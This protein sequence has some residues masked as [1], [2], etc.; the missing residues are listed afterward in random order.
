MPRLL[1]RRA[2][3]CAGLGLLE[4]LLALGLLGLTAAAAARWFETRLLEERARLAG[5]Q[6]AVL[7]EAAAG[8][9]NG[10]FPALL[11]AARNGPVELA[12]ADLRTAGAL[13]PGFP[14]V[15]ALGRGRRVLI[16][17]AGTD[18]LDVVAAQAVAAGDAAVP[19]A[20]LLEATGRVRLGLVAPDA[21][22]RLAGPALDADVSAFQAAFGGAPA[23]RALASLRRFDH[24]TVFGGQLY[25]TAVPGFPAA[26]RM[27]TDLD[28]GGHGIANAGAIGTDRLTV[29]DGLAVGGAL[30]VAHALIVGEALRVS[31]GAE[32]SGSI[33]AAGARIAGAISGDTLS[34][35]DEVRAAS[36]TAAGAVSAGSIGA[37]GTVAAG[38]ARLGS[39][40]SGT[41]TARSVTATD[42]SAAGAA[43]QAV[44]AAGR[45]DAAEG[46]FSTLTVGRCTGC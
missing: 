22:A 21:P 37:G 14:D 23:A 39:L 17:A 3:R 29:E 36:L 8:H 28:M 4:A 19:W 42:V 43:A 46:G 11:A 25:R 9:V 26:N 40:Q 24:R 44:R 18:A 1:T 27:E 12:L 33:A 32:V 41:V 2:R 38:S 5:R 20:A 34:V 6:L 30:T 31:G 45:V 13:P 10:R 35:A 16:L 7:S 15:D